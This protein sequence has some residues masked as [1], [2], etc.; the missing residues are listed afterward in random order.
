MKASAMFFRLLDRFQYIAGFIAI[1]ILPLLNAGRVELGRNPRVVGVPVVRAGTGSRIVLGDKVSLVSSNLSYHA[2][3][4]A[5]VKIFA[6]RP[7]AVITIGDNT[8]INGACLHAWKSITIGRNCL[9]AANVQ[10][11]DANGH[12]LCMDA[13]ERRL[14]TPDT[15]T[16]ITIGDNV[17]IGLNSIVLPG[18]KLGDGCVVAAGS[19]VKGDFAA[20]SIIGGVPA[21]V[22][23]EA[24]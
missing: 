11:M 15:P 13:P 18:T 22:I 14:V 5:P 3:M 9:I 8:R 7:G 6:D 16:P 23:R 1:R 12:D 20:G 19:V 4:F 2:Q 21:K 17:W 24:S 10:I